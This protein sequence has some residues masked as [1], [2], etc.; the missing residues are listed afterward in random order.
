M[1]AQ[2]KV[3]PMT[4]ASRG[5]ERVSIYGRLH[6]DIS[7]CSTTAGFIDGTV[8]GPGQEWCATRKAERH[9]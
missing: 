7:V 2:D 1:R 6:G 3:L 9:S 5:F 8:G 4:A